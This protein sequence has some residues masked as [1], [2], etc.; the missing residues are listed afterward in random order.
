MLVPVSHQ[1]EL[2]V[3]QEAAAP[4]MGQPEG[5]EGEE[6]QRV[7]QA[8]CRLMKETENLTQ[9]GKHLEQETLAEESPAG[10]RLS[11]DMHEPVRVRRRDGGKER[12][13]TS[14]EKI[15]LCKGRSNVFKG[16]KAREP[17]HLSMSFFTVCE[18]FTALIKKN[19][20]GQVSCPVS[21]T[22]IRF[23][24]IRYASSY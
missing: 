2:G 22:Q 5:S 8:Y 3:G 9:Q 7:T 21:G 14:G 17:T 24:L 12:W 19:Q 6:K 11:S 4:Q 13:E 20:M 16:L 15:E 1:S 23:Y 18:I 10:G